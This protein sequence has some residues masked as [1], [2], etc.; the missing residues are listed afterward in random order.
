MFR[1]TASATRS[2]ARCRG[3]CWPARAGNVVSTTQIVSVPGSAQARVPV[4]PL[5][6]NVASEQAGLP[7]RVPMANP[8]PRGG[9]PS[10]L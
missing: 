3:C 6:P 10:G 9:S 1:Q 7:A 5:W 4:D 2:E 8:R